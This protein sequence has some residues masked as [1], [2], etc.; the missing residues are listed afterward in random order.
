LYCIYAFLELSYFLVK[1]FRGRDLLEGDI[2][3]TTYSL[4]EDTPLKGRIDIHV[5]K[6]HSMKEDSG[7]MKE[8]WQ[9]EGHLSLPWHGCC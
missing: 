5:D 3:I 4:T 1:I 8:G 2:I 7:R 6:K 9:H